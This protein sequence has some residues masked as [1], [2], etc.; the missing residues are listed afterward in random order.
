[1]SYGVLASKSV[2]VMV[3]TT[4][5][6]GGSDSDDVLDR[7]QSLWGATWVPGRL[8]ATRLHVSVIPTR[9]GAGLAIM[10]LNLRDIGVVELGG[11]RV[12][13]VM[14]LRTATHVVHVRA[15]GAEKLAQEVATLVE[16]AKRIP[17][18]RR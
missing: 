13:K 7:F 15:L 12:S 18:R 9:A 5:G 8:T 16:A 4:S 14:G 1:M 2:N 10:N 17:L 6:V 11:G 3:E